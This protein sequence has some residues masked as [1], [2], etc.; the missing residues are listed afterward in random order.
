MLI[1]VVQDNDT[2][3]VGIVV[4][5]D[6]LPAAVHHPE[7]FAWQ[8]TV[9]ESLEFCA[10]TMPTHPIGDPPQCVMRFSDVGSNVADGRAWALA[11]LVSGPVMVT[12]VDPTGHIVLFRDD[13]SHWHRRS[14]VAARTAG[15]AVSG[16]VA[17]RV[18]SDSDGS[19]WSLVVEAP[20]LATIEHRL[21]RGPW[22]ACCA[23]A[24]SR[25][26]KF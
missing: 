25:V 2:G 1:D 10:I 26:F 18:D 3:Q 19:G 14:R 21:F 11:L 13:P 17:C 12:V 24:R 15:A 23:L 20:A 5:A 8:L 7:W 6:A 16:Q 22:S 4:T 9:D